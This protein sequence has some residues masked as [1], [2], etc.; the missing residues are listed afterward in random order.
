MGSEPVNFAKLAKKISTMFKDGAKNNLKAVLIK[1]K[2][3]GFYFDLASNTFIPIKR[4]SEMYYLPLAKDEKNNFYI[5][6]PYSFSQGV[7]ILVPEEEIEF[8]GYN[9]GIYDWRFN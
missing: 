3:V 5:F 4:H 2:G 8:I 6:L 1:K 7:I 9:W